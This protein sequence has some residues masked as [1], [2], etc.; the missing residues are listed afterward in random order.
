MENLTA[1]IPARYYDSILNRKNILPFGDSNLLAHKISQLQTVAQVDS[2]VVSSDSEEILRI[3]EAQGAIPILRP[4]ELA[5]LQSNFGEFIEHITEVVQSKH[6]L[7]ACV[8]SPFVDKSCYE[9]AIS[10]YFEKIEEG[11]D[12]LITIQKIRR[13]LLDDNG[14]LNFRNSFEF[15][16][17]NDLPVLYEFTNGIVLAP[18]ESMKKWRYNWGKIP[19]K[20]ELDRIH[21]IDICDQN[22]YEYAKY[23]Y[24]RMTQL[25]KQQ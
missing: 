6:I 18:R 22:D 2:I 4:T 1:V 16:D 14:P 20:M 19:A 5:T 24:E 9:K 8:T 17:A 12:S 3:A 23:L 11:Y 10:L 25:E 13:F 15:K 21:S 7:W